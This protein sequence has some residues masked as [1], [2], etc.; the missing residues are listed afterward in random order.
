MAKKY[1]ENCEGRFYV[2]DRCINCSLCTLIAPELFATNH[3]Q[4]YEY[5]KRQP[6]REDEFV[7]VAEIINICPADAVVDNKK[8]ES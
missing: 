5:L 7:L 2:D 6:R 1:P 4:G 8:Y 3:E